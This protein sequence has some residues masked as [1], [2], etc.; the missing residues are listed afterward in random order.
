MSSFLEHSIAVVNIL[1]YI[2]SFKARAT[3]F[4]FRE[5]SILAGYFQERILNFFSF[6]SKSM[7]HLADVAMV[8]GK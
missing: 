3:S 6:L 4:L 2:Y 1:T 7:M 8:H 5:D